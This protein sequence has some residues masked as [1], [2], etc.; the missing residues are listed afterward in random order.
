MTIEEKKASKILSEEGVGYRRETEEIRHLGVA[1]A[2]IEEAAYYRLARPSGLKLIK[3]LNVHLT[4]AEEKKCRKLAKL[5]MPV[6]GLL[7][8]LNVKKRV[9]ESS[10]YVKIYQTHLCEK[11]SISMKSHLWLAMK[12][13]WLREAWN[14]KMWERRREEKPIFWSWLFSWYLEESMLL[15]WGLREML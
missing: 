15:M 11:V 9:R 10:V 8:H 1:W 13:K 4:E 3:C 7:S 14:V 5:S 2:R 12:K 6:A